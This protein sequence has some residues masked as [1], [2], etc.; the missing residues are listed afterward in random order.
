MKLVICGGTGYVATELIRQGLALPQISNLVVLSRRP[1]T[2]PDGANAAKL[3]QVLIEKYDEYPDNVKK[4]LSGASGCIWTVAITP[5][6]ATRYDFEVVRTVCQTSTMAFLNAF[7]DTKPTSKFRF[8]YMSGATVERDQ[9]KRPWFHADYVLM[10]GETESKVEAFAKEHSDHVEA[11]IVKPGL[12]TSTA[13]LTR[14]ASSAFLKGLSLM[15]GFIQSLT[16]QEI[17]AAMLSQVVNGFEKDV[18]GTDDLKR[19]GQDVL[20]KGEE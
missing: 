1:I 6:K 13:T 5:S 12:I 19:I 9:T 11:Q 10:R 17:S 16:V 8:I 3:K 4:E 15:V 20:S 7:M 18:L 2:V 14:A